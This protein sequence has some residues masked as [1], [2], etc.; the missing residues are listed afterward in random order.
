MTFMFP[1]IVKYNYEFDKNDSSQF[2]FPITGLN[3]DDELNIGYVTIYNL[4]NINYETVKNLMPFVKNR[5]VLSKLN[6]IA[7]V[8]VSDVSHFWK[9]KCNNNLSIALMLIKQAIGLIYLTYYEYKGYRDSKRI[10]ISENNVHEFE[11]GMGIYLT[12]NGYVNDNDISKDLYFKL[13]LLLIF[14][15]KKEQRFL[16]SFIKWIQN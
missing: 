13:I 3:I 6:I 12:S 14:C 9:E 4:K 7:Y 16:M 11:E 15:W 2:I 10:I 5:N 8:D 1:Q